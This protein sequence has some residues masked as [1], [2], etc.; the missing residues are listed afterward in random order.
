MKNIVLLCVL[1]AVLGGGLCAG[2]EA[3]TPAAAARH[4]LIA[5]DD[6]LEV[7][8]VDVPELSRTY[9]VEPDG[10]LKFPF[11]KTPVAAAGMTLEEFAAAVAGGLK[12]SGA[13]SRAQVSA[14]LKET[15]FSAVAVTGAVNKPQV[16][17]VRG[18]A[19]LLD[20]LAEAGGLSDAAGPVVQITRG[21]AAKRAAPGEPSSLRLKVSEL[22]SSSVQRHNVTI[23]PGDTVTVPLAEVIYVVGAVNRPGGFALSATRPSVSVLQALALAEDVKATAKKERALIIRRGAENTGR[24]E[25]ALNLG[26]ILQ[27]KS[28]DPVLEPNDILFVPESGGKKAL[29]RSAEAAVQ[30]ATGIV[31]WRR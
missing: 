20:V 30:M 27:G 8:I 4:Y 1:A 25:I 28:P 26:K 14:S 19:R 13:V 23:Y 3:P 18:T 22:L 21:E 6:L 9:R 17:A 10:S 31:I 15:R 7:Y 16:Y 29:L 2:Q 11:L 5:P 24:E 12:E